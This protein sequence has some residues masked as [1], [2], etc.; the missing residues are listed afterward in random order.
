MT[1]EPQLHDLTKFLVSRIK[2][3]PE[4]FYLAATGLASKKWK[5][6]LA[7]T[8]IHGTAEDKAA[9]DVAGMGYALQVSLKTLLVPEE[10]KDD[11]TTDD[12]RYKATLRMPLLDESFTRATYDV[13]TQTFILIR[14]DGTTYQLARDYVEDAP[15]LVATM[16]ELMLK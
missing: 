1:D 16:R 10:E 8:N 15:D 7:V 3:Y 9:I 14:E 12:V 6:A 2:T 5:M 13:S 11:F 4:E